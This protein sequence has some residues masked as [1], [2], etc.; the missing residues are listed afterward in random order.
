MLHGARV[1]VSLAVA[2]ALSTVGAAA[3]AQEA[4]NESLDREARALFDAGS[5]AFEDARYGDALGYF[6]RAYELSHR[7]ALLYN[8][9]LAADRLRHDEDALAA[10]Q[11]FLAEAGDNPR[12]RE[13]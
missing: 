1:C 11:Q 13:V 5:T 7:P 10:F 2:F 12:R 9:G 8:I 3:R 6:R 4:S